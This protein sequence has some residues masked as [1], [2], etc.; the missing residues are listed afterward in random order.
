MTR[1]RGFSVAISRHHTG[2]GTRNRIFV[3]CLFLA[4]AGLGCHS[5]SSP[6]SATDTS[7][8]G[9]STPVPVTVRGLDGSVGRVESIR[10]ELRLVVLDYSLS[11]LPQLGDMLVVSREGT[12]VGLIKVTG[13]FR[14]GTG[15]LGG[16]IISGDL[17]IGDVVRTQPR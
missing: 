5:P 2:A 3:G 10:S 4:W 1:P 15:K 11:T 7:S 17:Q 16:E 6:P 12:E 14:A 9:K 13:P 8:G